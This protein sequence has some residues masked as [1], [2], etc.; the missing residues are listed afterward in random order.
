MIFW[1]YWCQIARPGDNI[2]PFY[3]FTSTLQYC[4]K[5]QGKARREEGKEKAGSKQLRNHKQINKEGKKQNKQTGIYA[6]KV[7][8]IAV[9][10]TP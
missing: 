6:D 9:T 1:G 8:L 5:A 7:L 10:T 3:R 4:S 2:L